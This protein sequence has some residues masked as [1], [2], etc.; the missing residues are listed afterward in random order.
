MSDGMQAEERE[1][2]RRKQRSVRSVRI[3][4]P[5]LAAARAISANPSAKHGLS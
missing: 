2:E 5:G 4:F 1:R 3:D